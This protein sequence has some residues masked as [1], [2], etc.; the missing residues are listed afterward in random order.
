VRRADRSS[1]GVLPTVVLVC[2]LGTSRMRRLKLIKGCKCR[3]E[4]EEEEE[5]EWCISNYVPTSHKKWV[6]KRKGP[7]TVRC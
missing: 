3:I 6:K 5:E 7:H 2:D 1:R 4:E